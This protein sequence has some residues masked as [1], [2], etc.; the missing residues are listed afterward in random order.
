MTRS[1]VSPGKLYAKCKKQKIP[2]HMW[3]IW[4]EKELAKV[5]EMQK[6]ALEVN[7]KPKSLLER[8]ND[9]IFK[10]KNTPRGR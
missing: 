10:T 3:Y 4:I 6:R 2:F 7:A 9:A 5:N 8:L 1:Q